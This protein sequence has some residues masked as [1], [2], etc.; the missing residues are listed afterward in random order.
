MEDLNVI[1]EMG[2]ENIREVAEG[3]AK[4]PLTT[5]VRMWQTAECTKNSFAM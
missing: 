3:K 5:S 2:K 4:M 1:W